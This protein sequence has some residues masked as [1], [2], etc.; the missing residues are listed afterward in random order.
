MRDRSSLYRKKRLTNRG[1]SKEIMGI[2]VKG[3]D[4]KENRMSLIILMIDIVGLEEEE[5]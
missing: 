3:G 1:K 5:R 4:T 2:V